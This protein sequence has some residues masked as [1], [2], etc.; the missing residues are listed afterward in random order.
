MTVSWTDNAN[1]E[2]GYRL[3][4]STDGINYTKIADLAANTTSTNATAAKP[5]E[6]SAFR[7][8]LAEWRGE[9]QLGANLGLGTVNR[10]AFTGH[11]KLTESHHFPG[12]DQTLRNI[13]D[14]DVAY[15]T[16]DDVPAERNDSALDFWKFRH[17]R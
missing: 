10:E 11:M 9:V 15:G 16:T 14:Y 5:A 8:F 1:N 3:Y 12:G 6:K 17:V 2:T 13:L 4:R 7:K